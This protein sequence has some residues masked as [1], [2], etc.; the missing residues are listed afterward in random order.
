MLQLCCS[1]RCCRL[2]YVGRN[3]SQLCLLWVVVHPIRR[4]Y[5]PSDRVQR[6]GSGAALHGRALLDADVCS[7]S[8]ETRVQACRR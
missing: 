2:R 7:L 6:D 1:V 3:C 4:H 5:T 8:E